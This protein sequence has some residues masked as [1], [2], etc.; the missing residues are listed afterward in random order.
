MPR[1]RDRGRSSGRD[2]R[3][4]GE[5]A[6]S[7]SRSAAR[8]N[9][10]I[11]GVFRTHGF[12][13]EPE[14]AEAAAPETA[15]GPL[16]WF[17]SLQGQRNI[18]MVSKT[19]ETEHLLTGSKS[20][21]LGWLNLDNS[22]DE[23]LMWSGF[24]E[25]EKHYWDDKLIKMLD[26]G[27]DSVLAVVQSGKFRGITAIGNGSDKKTK[28]RCAALAL[29]LTVAI[30]TDATDEQVL[31]WWSDLLPLVIECRRLFEQARPD[32]FGGD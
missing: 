11:Q 16:K 27:H 7:R 29:I 1:D 14:T 24:K 17:T 21:V 4:D 31:E 19:P 3:Q 18:L 13:E 10:R 2:R 20:A 15:H 8:R 22:I 5:R 23:H 12:S 32:M 25:H 30:E 6:R 28:V 9:W 26:E